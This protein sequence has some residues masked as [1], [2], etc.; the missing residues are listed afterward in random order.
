MKIPQYWSK[1]TADGVNPQGQKVSFSCWRWSDHSEDDARESA[2]AAARRVV[3]RII[4]GERLDR[5]GYGET[6]LR[7]E[8]IR[9][10]NDDQGQAVAAVVRNTYGSLVLNAAGVFFLD[11]DFP[12]VPVGEQIRH[13]FARLFGRSASSPIARREEASLERLE[14]FVA[15]NRGW[16]LRVY[17]TFAGLR[18][19]ATHDLFDPAAPATVGVME[20]LGT[21]P[22]YI[23]LCKAQ[24]CFRAR[25]TPKPWR[26]GHGANVIR[27]P[28]DSQQ[29]ERFEAWLTKYETV[30]EGYATCRFLKTLGDDRVHPQVASLLRLH[31]EMTRCLGSLELA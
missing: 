13:F 23:R 16:G 11:L 29:Q 7:E 12:P 28:R 18:A 31:D 20:A 17:R 27:W 25:L 24:G 5:Y 8:V 2:L 3:Q 4:L 21:D 9:R 19:V 6:P 22:L 14:R 10:F 30:Q 26:C 15:E 1:A